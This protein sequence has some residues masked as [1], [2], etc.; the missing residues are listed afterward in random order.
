MR[1][2]VCVCVFFLLLASMLDDMLSIVLELL[3]LFAFVS[4]CVCVCVFYMGVNGGFQQTD[5]QNS[6]DCEYRGTLFR[7]QHS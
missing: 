4:V 7:L 2:C 1:M 5:R 6:H 3:L